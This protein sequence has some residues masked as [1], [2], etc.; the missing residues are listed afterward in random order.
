[1]FSDALLRFAPLVLALRVVV[2]VR[3]NGDVERT[4]LRDVPAGVVATVERTSAASGV[5]S[6]D[7]F[8]IPRR[9]YGWRIEEER[10]TVLMAPAGRPTGVVRRDFELT[11]WVDT[12]PDPRVP[13][14]PTIAFRLHAPTRAAAEALRDR[15]RDA[16]K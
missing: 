1:M 10:R 4:S 15:L 14:T 11:A 16:L 7:R 3:P 5:V 2:A 9:R 8:R 13:P 6:V 12:T